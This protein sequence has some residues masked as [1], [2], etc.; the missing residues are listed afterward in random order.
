M[1]GNILSDIILPV[2]LSIM[3]LGLGMG[4]TMADFTRLLKYPKAIIIALFCQTII[5]PFCAFIVA[6]M[7]RLEPEIAV[8]LVLIAASP[9]G[10]TANLLSNLF[11]GDV[12]LSITL[13]AL[14]SLLSLFTLPVIVN[15]ALS[16]FIHGNEEITLPIS[17][18]LNVFALIL[19]PAFIGILIRRYWPAFANF[20]AK[21]VR[22]GSMA[23][24]VL[25]LVYIISSL[26][27]NKAAEDN[28][29]IMGFAALLFNVISLLFGYYLPRLLGISSRQATSI[30]LEIG[31][32]N[33]TLAIF[34]AVSILERAN[35]AISPALYGLFMFFSALTFGYFLKKE[36]VVSAA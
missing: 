9:G 34:I 15:I 28:F 27:G 26:I 32:H 33:T 3:M 5:L 6:W 19:V 36:N 16:F 13:T 25:L 21:P 24:V 14:N 20:F 10:S 35:I 4:L 31:I 17:K 2:G 12:A 29:A 7:L 1:Q 22:I 11:Y 8:G 30:A 23:L 18:V